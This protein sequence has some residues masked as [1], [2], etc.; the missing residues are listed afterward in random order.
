MN[1]P[2]DEIFIKMWLTQKDGLRMEL[3]IR[4][5]RKLAMKKHEI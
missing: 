4:Q 1:L 2:N 5:K 3:K